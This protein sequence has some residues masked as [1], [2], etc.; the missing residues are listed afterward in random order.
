MRRRT[1]TEDGRRRASKGGEVLSTAATTFRRC[2]A[3]TE[4]WTAFVLVL[5]C[6]RREQLRPGTAGTT[7]N[8]GCRSKDGGNPLVHGEDGFRR[9]F[10]AREPAAGLLLLLANPTAAA[11]TE[12]DDG[13]RRTARLERCLRLE[14]EGERGERRFPATAEDGT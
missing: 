10:G 2:A 1:A 5:R 6:R 14:R 4:G 11:A 9:D 3:T 7:A 13:R 12:G 8:G